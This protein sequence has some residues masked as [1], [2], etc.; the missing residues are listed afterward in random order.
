MK[1]C[2][3]KS[4]TLLSEILEE[5][6]E[7]Y[8]KRIEEERNLMERTFESRR[9]TYGHDFNRM[10]A[11]R[12]LERAGLSIPPINYDPWCEHKPE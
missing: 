9:E 6:P 10:W 7:R 8:A 1:P 12:T 11:S 2:K 4:V 3:D 5:Y